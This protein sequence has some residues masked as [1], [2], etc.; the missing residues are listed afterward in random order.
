MRLKKMTISG[1]RSFDK[2]TTIEFGDDTVFIGANNAGKTSALAALAKIFSQRRGERQIVRSDFH[3]PKD[4]TP[5]EVSELHMR[6]ECVFEFDELAVGE[7]KVDDKGDGEVKE[8][9]EGNTRPV[10]PSIFFNGMTVNGPDRIPILRVRLEASWSKSTNA[11]GAIDSRVV[12]IASPESVSEEL[13][14]VVPAPRKRLDA[15]RMIYIPASRDPN[16][17]TKYVTGSVMSSM[18]GSIKWDSDRRNKVTEHAENLSKLIIEEPGAQSV[19]DSINSAWSSYNPDDALAQASLAFFAGDFE[20]IVRDPAIQLT[21]SFLQRSSQVDELG[22]GHK[23]LFHLAMIHS[24][25]YLE[26]Q[27]RAHD[28]KIAN[29]F[30]FALP[31]LTIVAVEEPENHIA[32]HLLGHLVKRLEELWKDNSCQVVVTSHSPAIVGRIDPTEIRHFR[33]DKST[34]STICSYLTL[35]D[36]EDKA[37]KYVK[38]SLKAY[39]EVL[40][41]KAVVLGEGDSEAVVLPKLLEAKLGTADSLGVSIAPIGGRHAEHFWRLLNDLHIPHVTLLDYDQGREGGGKD[42]LKDAL[43]WL[44]AVGKITKDEVDEVKEK[45]AEVQLKYLEEQNVFYSWPLDLD[46]AMLEAFCD[47]Y[48]GAADFGPR[49]K[50]GIPLREYENDTNFDPADSDYVKRVEDA[51]KRVLHLNGGDEGSEGGDCSEYEFRQKRLMPWYQNLFLGSRGKPTT[52]RRA[53]LEIDT[54]QLKN[55]A[56]ESLIKLVETL[57]RLLSA[58]VEKP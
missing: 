14:Q 51:T 35:P 15:I 9:A 10:A 29:Q 38:A 12:F 33:L 36:N 48:K 3:L 52:H 21:P 49:L 41:A 25:I 44:R 40:F 23:S 24:L 37:Y 7:S 13:E 39:P 58:E 42:R 19:N 4:K 27:I 57:D 11:E 50:A 22:D 2:K 30:E 32:P 17:E 46:F 54:D 28:S 56:P 47:E 53:L 16:V 34:A 26:S 55:N 31:A 1:F 6:I 20:S 8:S 45:D 43:E 5:D 18:L